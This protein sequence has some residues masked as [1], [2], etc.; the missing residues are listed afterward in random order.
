MS[1]QS[2]AR[3]I[4]AVHAYLDRLQMGQEGW[5]EELATL[6]AYEVKR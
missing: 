6:T 4:Q 5:P 3:L 2:E 1:A